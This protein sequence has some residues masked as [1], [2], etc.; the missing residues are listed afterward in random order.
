MKKYS[1]IIW[2]TAAYL[3][4]SAQSLTFPKTEY[5]FSKIKE[6]DGKVSYSFTYEN[7]SPFSVSVIRID[8]P[9]RALSIN[10]K[11]DS[12]PS[13]TGKGSIDV[14]LNPK[15]LSGAF[16]H[17]FHVKTIE[18]SVNQTYTLTV[19]ANIEPRP[20]TKEEIYP[21]KEGNLRYKN[22]SLRYETMTPNTVIVDTF[23]IYNVSADT[24]TFSCK[25]LPTA[26]KIIGMPEKL[27]SMQEG[28]I[29]FEYSAAKKNDWG[30][31][32]ERISLN[33]NDPERPAKSLHITGNIYDD[34]STMTEKEKAN[35][36][37]ISVDAKEYNFGTA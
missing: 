24:M 23:F 36:A 31:V 22:N 28:K 32:F 2:F 17:T 9:N 29:V 14:T 5:D 12:I 27:A 15:D 25:N 11:R 18:N 26:F 8:N 3:F 19:K 7:H 33:T 10:F 4:C 37:K 16:S 34:F 30:Y 6:T 21:M 20:R 35:A 13:K 1:L